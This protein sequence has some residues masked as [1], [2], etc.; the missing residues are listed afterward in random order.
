MT[1]T[2]VDNT[3][4]AIGEKCGYSGY[5]GNSIENK[6][7]NVTHDINIIG[8][9]GYSGYM[10]RSGAPQTPLDRRKLEVIRKFYWECSTE[11]RRRMLAY[12]ARRLVIVC[13]VRRKS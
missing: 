13:D 5:T 2:I 9:S 12:A 10:P 11:E 7:K 1:H 8:Y 4:T 6:G 3:L